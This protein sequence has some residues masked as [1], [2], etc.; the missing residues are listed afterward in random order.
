VKSEQVRDR[1][2]SRAGRERNLNAGKIYIPVAGGQS[3]LRRTKRRVK[4]SRSE[5]VNSAW[6]REEASKMNG[7]AGRPGCFGGGKI[8]GSLATQK[9][10]IEKE[11]GVNHTVNRSATAEP[12]TLI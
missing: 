1:A 2:R 4:R 11:R 10:R 9:L 8:N 7:G 5:A 6:G 12:R 3:V